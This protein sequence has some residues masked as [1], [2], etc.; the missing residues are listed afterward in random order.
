MRETMAY[1]RKILLMEWEHQE[2]RMKIEDI[3]QQLVDIENVKVNLWIFNFCYATGKTV[4]IY[5][6]LQ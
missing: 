6:Q 4:Y 2:L 1:R 3:K 5:V